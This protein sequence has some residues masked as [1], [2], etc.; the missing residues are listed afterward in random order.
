VAA[1]ANAIGPNKSLVVPR[2]QGDRTLGGPASL[3]ADAH[4]AGLS[5]HPWTFRAENHFL[6]VDLRS[7]ENPTEQGDLAA[8]IRAFLDAGVDGFFTDHPALGKIARDSHVGPS[9]RAARRS[10]APE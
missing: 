9:L 2:T 10:R 7:S 8:E 1:Y 6:P 3:V 5:V 4:K